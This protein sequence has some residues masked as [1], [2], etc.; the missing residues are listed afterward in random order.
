MRTSLR[1]LLALRGAT[2]VIKRMIEALSFF[3]G[4]T[5]HFCNAAKTSL[6]HVLTLSEVLLA[7]SEARSAARFA[8]LPV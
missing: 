1:A 3:L 8:L 7:D 2:W 5:M 6:P 4:G